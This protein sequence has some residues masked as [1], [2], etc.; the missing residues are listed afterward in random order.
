[1]GVKVYIQGPLFS[2]LRFMNKLTHVNEQGAAQMV[3]ISSKSA[4]HREAIAGCTV[5]MN[6]ETLQ[7]IVDNT[8]K[9][10]DVL[11]V[12][13]VAGIQ[14]AKRCS[15]L[16]PL[17]HPLPLTSVTVDFDIDTVQNEILVSCCCRV[18]HKTGVEMEA[19][20]GASIAALTIY[21][22]CKAVEKGMLIKETKLL[23]KLGGKS[24]P[25]QLSE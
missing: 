24:G 20:T 22:M 4:T 8:I 25:W 19:L 9:K 7:M 17:C 11:S 6:K 16:I 14:A 3:D 15:D 12:A 10:G 2:D 18:D 23:K 5:V 21:D 13:R 1:M